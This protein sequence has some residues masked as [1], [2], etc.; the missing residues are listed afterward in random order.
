MHLEGDSS[1]LSHLPCADDY[2]R[3]PASR[4]RRVMTEQIVRYANINHRAEAADEIEFQLFKPFE[5]LARVRKHVVDKEVE[6]DRDTRRRS[7]SSL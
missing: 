7:P 2:A 3:K 4:P 5:Q 1:P 6:K